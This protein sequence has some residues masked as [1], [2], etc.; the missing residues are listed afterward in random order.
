MSDIKLDMDLNQE[1]TD[2]NLE[3]MEVEISQARAYVCQEIT[4]YSVEILEYYS[5]KFGKNQALGLTIESV[6]ESLGNLISLV[7]ED[8]QAEVLHTSQQVVAQGIINQQEL[9]AELAYGQVGHA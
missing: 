1:D 2:H 7:T 3:Q 4:R 5:N 8:H 9:I 6:S